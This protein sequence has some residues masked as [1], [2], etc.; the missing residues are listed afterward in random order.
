MANNIIY[1]VYHNH[2]SSPALIYH[3]KNAMEDCFELRGTYHEEPNPEEKINLSR[4][5]NKH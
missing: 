3:N 5:S 1:F 4:I 2:L